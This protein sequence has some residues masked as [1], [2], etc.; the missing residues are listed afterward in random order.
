[1][2]AFY[3][4]LMS[5]NRAKQ[6]EFYQKALELDVIFDTADSTGMGA[7]GRVQLIIRQDNDPS[8]HHLT[9]QKGP[10]I[11]CFD[12][13]GSSQTFLERMGILGYQIRSILPVNEYGR[14]YVFAEDADANEICV[15]FLHP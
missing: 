1:M 5:P 8:S 10:V 7:E 15:S 13:Q 3:A 6:V 11:L 14:S 2:N 4:V 9:A 12:M